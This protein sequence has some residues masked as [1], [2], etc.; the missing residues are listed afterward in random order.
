MRTKEQ[1]KEELWRLTAAS[2]GTRLIVGI[3]TFSD[4]V[5]ADLGKKFT[6][7][8]I[9]FAIAMAMKYNI[10]LQILTFVGY[11]TETEKHIDNAIKWLDQH[12][13]AKSHV[14]ITIG[15]PMAIL[16]NSW[17]DQNIEQLGIKFENNN[18]QLWYNKQSSFD[19]R[20]AWH[21]RILDHVKKLKYKYIS[22][23]TYHWLLAN[24][25]DG[26][27]DSEH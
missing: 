8:D 19:Q 10:H 7:E 14:T 16:K 9:D 13:Y 1:F 3:E 15:T 26:V 12:Q 11:I 5:R 25:I 20:S 17:I 4:D 24:D 2:G 23:S 18:R 27:V 22:D 6:N 21:Q